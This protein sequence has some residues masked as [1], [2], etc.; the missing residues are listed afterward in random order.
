MSYMKN[1][2]YTANEK[3]WYPLFFQEEDFESS[4]SH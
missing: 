1:C 4:Q 2:D 3:D